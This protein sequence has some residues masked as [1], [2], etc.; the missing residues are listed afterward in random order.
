MSDRVR[1]SSAHTLLA[2]VAVAGERASMRFLEFFAANIRNRQTRRAMPGNVRAG[3]EFLAC[4]AGVRVASIGDIQPVPVAACIEAVTRELAAPSV[5]QQLVT[6]RQ[7]ETTCTVF[8]CAW[9]SSVAAQTCRRPSIRRMIEAFAAV[10][11]AGRRLASI[12]PVH[13]YYN[14]SA[15]AQRFDPC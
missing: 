9:V 5:K 11:A 3:E 1:I 8:V 15:V 2:L 6:I 7:K 13:G 14:S 10:V 4:C 12:A